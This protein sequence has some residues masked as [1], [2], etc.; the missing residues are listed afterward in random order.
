M[1]ETLTVD[2]LVTV[3]QEPKVTLLR[4][5]L[6]TLGAE[7]CAALLADTLTCEAHGGLLT[8][9]GTR[10]R[11]PGGVFFQLVKEACTPR[12]RAR[13]FLAQRRPGPAASPSADPRPFTWPQ[14][15]ELAPTLSAHPRGDATM[16]LTL[17]GR[18][19]HVEVRGQVAVLLMQGAPPPPLAKGLPAPTG[20]PLRWTVLVGLR[21]WQRVKESFE[22]HAE[23]K[24]IIEGYP[25]LEGERHVLLA[26]SCIS[27]L[28]QR[29]R[30][31]A[32]HEGAQPPAASED[33]A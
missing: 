12:E 19:G 1:D 2:H 17:V 27:M 15:V 8:K 13:L 26:Q 29:A 3:L 32:Q 11:T 9:D 18:P 23:D 33:P 22:Q 30:K 28:Q 7:R 5:V 16:K 24:L 25:C 31:Q 6:R 4:Q 20:T 14:L 21:Q 10:R